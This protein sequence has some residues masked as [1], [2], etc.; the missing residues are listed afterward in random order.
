M[1]SDARKKEL[2]AMC[3][4]RM[5]KKG[6]DWM[7][8]RQ[9]TRGGDVHLGREI[10]R[11]KITFGEGSNSYHVIRHFAH[12]IEKRRVGLKVAYKYMA[13]DGSGGETDG[14]GG[15]KVGLSAWS[16]LQMPL[17]DSVVLST[18][19]RLRGFIFAPDESSNSWTFCWMPVTSRP[20]RGMTLSRLL[21]GRRKLGN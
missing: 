13:G 10:R 8:W 2:A 9:G 4:G 5:R 7:R 14:V 3:H 17:G 11:R 21:T 20:L 15:Y 6:L 19:L 18:G 12:R 16:P 1:G